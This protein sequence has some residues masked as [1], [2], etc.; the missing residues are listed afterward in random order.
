MGMAEIPQQPL[1][2]E[3]RYSLD[4]IDLLHHPQHQ[5]RADMVDAMNFAH[6]AGR[7]PVHQAQQRPRAPSNPDVREIA[8]QRMQEA[9]HIVRKPTLD[10]LKPILTSKFSLYLELNAIVSFVFQ[11]D[12]DQRVAQAKPADMTERNWQVSPERERVQ[13][14]VDKEV[15]NFVLTAMARLERR[16]EEGRNFVPVLIDEIRT[17]TADARH[18]VPFSIN[19]IARIKI[20]FFH[21]IAKYAFP[22][23]LRYF[24]DNAVEEA[25]GYFLT[26]DTKNTFFRR[27]F[28]EITKLL[29][30]YHG[31][32]RNS[33]RTHRGT[34]NLDQDIDTH[35]ATHVGGRQGR[36]HN[37]ADLYK[38]FCERILPRF[39]APLQASVRVRSWAKLTAWEPTNPVT[40]TLHFILSSILQVVFYIPYKILTIIEDILNPFIRSEIQKGIF[41]RMPKMIPT[42]LTKMQAQLFDQSKKWTEILQKAFSFADFMHQMTGE[43]NQALRRQLFHNLREQFQAEDRQRANPQGLLETLMI[44]AMDATAFFIVDL[45]SILLSDP[46]REA[47]GEELF[48]D[49]CRLLDEGH[50]GQKA[51][52]LSE[53]FAFIAESDICRHE[54]ELVV[55]PEGFLFRNFLKQIE[56]SAEFDQFQRDLTE[57]FSEAPRSNPLR[58]LLSL[59]HNQN[60]A[61]FNFYFQLKT[62][63]ERIPA[64]GPLWQQFCVS[65]NTPDLQK[66]MEI[67][68]RLIASFAQDA[69][70]I[71]LIPAAQVLDETAQV[72]DARRESTRLYTAMQTARDNLAKD[73]FDFLHLESADNAGAYDAIRD[74]LDR[75]EHIPEEARQVDGLPH[76]RLYFK[77]DALLGRVSPF[78]IAVNMCATEGQQFTYLMLQKSLEVFTQQVDSQKLERHLNLLFET[79]C[80]CFEPNGNGGHHQAIPVQDPLHR[81]PDEQLSD[82]DLVRRREAQF[83]GQFARTLNQHRLTQIAN[84][85][86]RSFQADPESNESWPGWFAN[87]WLGRKV[88]VP[89]LKK[90]EEKALWDRV[91]QPYSQD[92]HT[93]AKNALKRTALQHALVDRVMLIAVE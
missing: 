9:A 48:L 63:A 93:A 33:L 83:D 15:D 72:R 4:E 87:T 64:A 20:L 84:I 14:A 1:G 78:N 52:K 10:E 68:H 90:T 42:M 56:F 35:F 8:Q 13:E 22:Y 66:Q 27:L 58:F 12:I 28:E 41:L 54:L 79:M 76:D 70:F 60:G 16:Q 67:F 73:L 65:L 40:R 3:R 88:V 5:R 74:H 36:L 6:P 24:F 38:T 62:I 37:R 59:A 75:Q 85:F 77:A 61:S 71:A 81:V 55:H 69:E 57:T 21:I 47:R 34:T 29:S 7:P 89:L 39:L 53:I 45:R 86:I 11:R 80:E 19:L 44:K 26:A 32:M 82:K 30:D 50:I 91:L 18:T 49:F 2:R 17:W 23:F 31:E 43:T 92:L 25:K 46:D 51:E